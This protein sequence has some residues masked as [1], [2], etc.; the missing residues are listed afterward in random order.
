MIVEL[1]DRWIIRLRGITVS[2][3][4]QIPDD[5][6]LIVE[7]G[8]GQ[9]VLKTSG[10]VRLTTGPGSA[11]DAVLVIGDEVA[12]LVGSTVLSLVAFKTGSL[13][14]IF[15][16]GHHLNVRGADPGATGHLEIPGVFDWS[17]C[18]GVG[19]MR[20]SDPDGT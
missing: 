17:S 18:Q 5:R 16:T 11:P 12:E 1:E 14:A 4:S 9:V 7:M 20:L 15:S 8:D 19:R 3:V 6:G 2:A 13:R 10:C